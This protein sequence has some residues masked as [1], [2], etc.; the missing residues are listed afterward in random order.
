M[1]YV[2]S[3]FIMI[4]VTVPSMDEARKIA[5]L[6]VDKKLAGCVSIIPNI[7]SVYSCN[8]DI[9]EYEEEQILIKTK[10]SLFDEIVSEI[11]KVHTYKL[12]EIIAVPLV[13]TSHDYL[14]WLCNEMK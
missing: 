13:A 2:A 9:E 6:L 7:V 8:K 4:Y 1:N 3:D 5:K 10:S 12:P 14:M 11:T